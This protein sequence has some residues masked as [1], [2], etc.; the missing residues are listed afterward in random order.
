MLSRLYFKLDFNSLINSSSLETQIFPVDMTIKECNDGQTIC[1]LAGYESTVELDFNNF[2]SGCEFEKCNDVENDKKFKFLSN[3]DGDK[4]KIPTVFETF[5]RKSERAIKSSFD[6]NFGSSFKL[7]VWVRR[8]YEIN[9]SDLNEKEHVL[10]GSDSELLNRHHYGFYF[11][12]KKVK[13]L[14]RKEHN[15]E[16]D[17]DTTASGEFYPSL[18]EWSIDSIEGDAKWHFYEIKYEYP[19]AQLFIDGIKFEENQTNSDIIDAYEL[20]NIAATG[21]RVTYIGA[22]YNARSRSFTNFFNGDVSGLS[23]ERQT[24]QKRQT[25]ELQANSIIECVKNCKEYLDLNMIGNENYL[26]SIELT[27]YNTIK[28]NTQTLYDMILLLNKINYINKN[29]AV[30]DGS[31]LKQ[32]QIGKRFVKLNTNIK[33]YKSIKPNGNIKS[34]SDDDIF[35]IHV[36]ELSLSIDVKKPKQEFNVNIDGNKQYLVNK[37]TILN[38]GILLFKDVKINKISINKLDYSQVVNGEVNLNANDDLDDDSVD[39]DDIILNEDDSSKIYFS[40]C[41]I[42]ILPVNINEKFVVTSFNTGDDDYNVNS[43]DLSNTIGNIENN[44]KITKNSD[45]FVIDGLNTIES[46]EN[47]LRNLIYIVDSTNTGSGNNMANSN[48]ID[49][50]GNKLNLYK[51][52]YL[53]CIRNEPSIETNT[54]LV[55]V[56]SSF[57]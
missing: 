8:P 10:C 17:K 25:N 9:E 55:Q 20:E 56:S 26:K 33:C 7:N 36:N 31:T 43:D 54:V 2:P 39:D 6:G 47:Y 32:T 22:C 5:N 15:N 44:F 46:Y 41:S 3:T 49:E 24:V 37:N 27:Q 16:N 38:N 34:S 57:I 45:L 23:L 4:G 11:F 40:S 28:L 48:N 53:S 29:L 19:N 50:D 13:F 21:L 30:G 1:D 52:F 12:N 18:W 14:L 51:Q 42:R 35:K